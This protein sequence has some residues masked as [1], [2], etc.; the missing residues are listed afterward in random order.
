MKKLSKSLEKYV[1]PPGNYKGYNCK[2]RGGEGGPSM[3]YIRVR[4][5]F[6][7]INIFTNK[8]FLHLLIV[9]NH[10]V[11]F[12]FYTLRLILVRIFL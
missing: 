3:S 7:L 1:N 8:I 9:E 12:N 10:A 5:Q 6:F 4:N 11:E 2:E